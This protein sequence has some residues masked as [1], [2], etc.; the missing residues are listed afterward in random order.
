VP[1]ILSHKT[2]IPEI[3]GIEIQR[4]SFELALKN[5]DVNGLSGRLHLFM[6]M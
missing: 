6:M 5:L 3:Y 1:L 2:G 4:E